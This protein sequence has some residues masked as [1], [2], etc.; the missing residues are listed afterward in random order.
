MNGRERRPLVPAIL[1]SLALGFHALGAAE[2]PLPTLT[3]A[4]ELRNLPAAEAARSYPVRLRA[5]ITLVEPA[6]TV[7]LRD[8]TG[9]A[10]RQLRTARLRA[11][12][13]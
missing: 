11:I 6:R 8:E 13:L 12:P 10:A 5:V 2:A 3:T 9:A 4:R 1:V 7:F